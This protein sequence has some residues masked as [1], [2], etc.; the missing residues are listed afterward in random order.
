VA[1][2]GSGFLGGKKAVRE[3]RRMGERLAHPGAAP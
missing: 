3:Q 1:E 2:I